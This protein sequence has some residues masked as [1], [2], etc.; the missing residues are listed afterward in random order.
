METIVLSN[1]K[2]GIA[3]SLSTINLATI[4][5]LAGKRVLVVDNDVQSNSTQ[6]FKC[7]KKTDCDLND[8]L[9]E[10]AD[11][12][13]AIVHSEDY[14]V[15]V[16]VNSKKHFLSDPGE[17]LM[18]KG[19]LSFDILKEVLNEVKDEYDYAFIDNPPD[20][21]RMAKIGIAAADHIL[22][23]VMADGF[24]FEGISDAL[25]AI[26]YIR[27]ESSS[28]V[29]IMGVFLAR[30][31]VNTTNFYVNYHSYIDSLNDL[32]LKYFIRQDT[33]QS[34]ACSS[35]VPVYYYQKKTKAGTDYINL[36]REI[37]ILDE[38]AFRKL[39]KEYTSP[40]TELD[41]SKYN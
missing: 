36:A 41:I 28:N 9:I 32:A 5:Q 27:K 15:D 25:T 24:S 8:V 39:K 7:Y 22:L 14:G 1:V 40:L 10:D 4:M 21:H 29:D 20:L 31:S 23:P 3:K 13:D 17:E 34:E 12:R 26:D 11:I 35:F 6:T 2:G 38:K 16:L 33:K 18:L 19:N 37:G 30:V